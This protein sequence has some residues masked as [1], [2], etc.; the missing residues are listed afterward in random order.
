MRILIIEDD[1]G[2]SALLVR[3]FSAHGDA[4]DV[5]ATGQAGISTASLWEYGAIVLDR[6]LPDMDGVDVC[7]TLRA[8]DNATPILMLTVRDALADRIE[9]L[10]AGA[11][12]YLSKPFE[13][14]ELMAR[15]R[16]ISRRKPALEQ[17]SITVGPLHI[18]T[19]A[20]VASREGG[21]LELTRKEY[22]VLEILA[23]NAG[24]VVSRAEITEYVWD[25]NHDPASNALEVTINRL[26]AKVD[27]QGP[28]LIHTRRGAGYVLE[29]T[30]A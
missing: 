30:E 9:G 14:D 29:S 6:N 27:A 5:A 11:D 8:R 4:V 24:R 15:L 3:A 12:D 28:P 10:D 20:Q 7:R 2:L 17:A 18:D 26:R 16:A 23:R 19:R 25:Q 13:I 1:P 21:R 22:M